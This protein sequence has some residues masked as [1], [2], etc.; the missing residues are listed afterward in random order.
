M[1]LSNFFE[2]FI[3]GMALGIFASSP[4]GYGMGGFGFGYGGGM[5]SNRVD[6]GTFANPFPNI[7]GNTTYT[8][9]PSV[10]MY[11]GF[12]NPVFPTI[13]FS[14]I[15]KTIW[16]NA[17]N[18]D[19]DYNKRL[20]EYYENLSKNNNSQNYSN[21]TNITGYE[22]PFSSWYLPTQFNFSG[23]YPQYQAFGQI[24]A[25]KP[26]ASQ[27]S[28]AQQTSTRSSESLEPDDTDA[29][30]LKKAVSYDITEL[31]NK[32]SK[33]KNL[34]DEFYNKVIDISK[35]IK[36]DP[37]D[38]MGVMWYETAHTFNPA[39]TNRIGAT[40]LIQFMPDTAKALGTTTDKLRAMSAVEQLDY[41]EKFL[42][43]NKT[44]AGYKDSD[45]LDRGTLYSL[46][47][48]PG[49]SKRSVLTSKGENFYE[50][51]TNLDYN[52]DNKITKADLNSVITQH[53]A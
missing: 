19:S 23:F 47:F 39:K 52:K 34:P 18:P 5:M 15:D 16:D 7:F 53:M 49:R 10:F 3:G 26:K 27:T 4:Y 35:K 20:K 32:W 40:G 33:K 17:F 38:L 37:N 46:V 14:Q 21:Q 1:G 11:E 50:Q 45:T 31:K 8:S 44:D 25:Q 29:D 30:S 36:C 41:V 12:A 24:T 6:F 2:N 42:V 13:D 9:T 22:M 48:L 28:Q 51:N 43:K